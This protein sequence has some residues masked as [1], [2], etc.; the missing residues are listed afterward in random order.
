MRRMS[1]LAFLPL[2][3]FLPSPGRAQEFIPPRDT[4]VDTTASTIRLGIFGFGTRLGVDFTG[5]NQAVLSPTL[6]A[7]DLFSDRV[8]FRPS[9][10]VGVGDSATTYVGN[11]ELMYRFTADQEA[12]VPYVAFGGAVYSQERCGSAVD[13]P[14]VWAQ[15]ALGFEIRFRQTMNWLL[16]Y[17]GE[18][19]LRRHR[20]F[21][22]LT[23]RRGQ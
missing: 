22:G 17:H 7:G 2:L 10:E 14:R 23:T 21:I 11:L 20:F 19:G 13:C 18:D 3:P 9:V 4:T 1:W 8:R 6:D 16:E 15:F 5:K 12:A